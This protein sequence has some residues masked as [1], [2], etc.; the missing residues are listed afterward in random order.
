MTSEEARGEFSEEDQQL[1]SALAKRLYFPKGI[2]SQGAD[3]KQKGKRIK[4]RQY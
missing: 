3:A 2:L 4:G 1:L